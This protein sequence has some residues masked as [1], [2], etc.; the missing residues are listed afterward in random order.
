MKIAGFH[1]GHDSSYAILDKG[2]PK[3]HIE[4][5]RYSRRKKVD[6]QR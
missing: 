5:E 3:A 6:N 2:I 1:S 4:L